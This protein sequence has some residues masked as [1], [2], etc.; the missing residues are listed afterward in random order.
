MASLDLSS[1]FDVVNIDL[2]I[3]RL[4]IIGIPDDII[5]LI[6]VWLKNR[7]FYVMV[8]ND[9]SEVHLLDAGTVQG[10][11]LGPILYA[12]FVSPMFDLA[13]MTLF[14]DDNYLICWNKTIQELID[15]M[16]KTIELVIKW[17]RQ[18]GLKVNDSK[19]EL[20]LFYRKDT[21][22]ITITV[23]NETLISKNHMNVLGVT[24]DSKM[25]WHHQIQNTINK[26]KTALNAIK[27]IRKY[28]NKNQLL[29]IITSNYYSILYY[30]AEVWLLPTL[31]PQLKQ[32][33]LSASSSPLRLTT[34][35]YNYLI[36]FDTLH[37]VNKRATPDMIKVYK[38]ALLLHK[39][40]NNENNNI[41]WI[42]LFFTQ[43]F[44]NRDRYIKFFNSSSYKVG[45]N[46]LTNRF[47][48]LNGKIE[49][50]WLNDSFESFKI[51]CKKLFLT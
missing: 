43:N 44:N 41:N 48:V 14:A 3:K 2:L 40:Y 10:S 9:S 1:A 19:T 45:N 37:Y 46:L 42:D 22:P 28:F 13:K 51:K 30:N 21:A 4:I 12:I 25:Q 50:D 39:V 16:T 7:T 26:A 5:S 11:I 29:D 27:L 38:H 8:G 24:F 49:L 20:C 33:L 47:T 15:D 36:S 18:S 6:S 35:N 34:N 32:K 17:L 31:N 23:F